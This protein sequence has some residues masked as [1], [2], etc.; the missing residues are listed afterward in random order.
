VLPETKVLPEIRVTPGLKEKRVRR[1]A[2]ANKAIKDRKVTK[3]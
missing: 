1:D 2:L 3:V